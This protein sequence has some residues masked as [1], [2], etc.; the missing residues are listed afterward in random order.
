MVASTSN[1]HQ[2]GFGSCA[3]HSYLNTLEWDPYTGDF[4][5]GFWGA[6]HSATSMIISHPTFGWQAYG[7]NLNISGSQGNQTLTMQPRDL[8]RRRVFIA[9]IQLEVDLNAGYIDTVTYKPGSRSIV[10]L[11]LVPVIPES[12]AIP[13]QS[14]VLR[15]DTR[16]TS[17]HFNVTPGMDFLGAQSYFFPPNGSVT[18]TISQT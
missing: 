8:A 17:L 9:P 2:D 7:G 6:A 10:E 3:F 11:R 12:G 18:V 1:I 13:A 14:A 16:N 5:S 15:Y 4:G